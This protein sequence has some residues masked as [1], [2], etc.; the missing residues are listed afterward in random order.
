[1]AIFYEDFGHKLWKIS[2]NLA[3]ACASYC[4][5]ESLCR[6][7]LCKQGYP[8]VSSFLE[9]LSFSIEKVWKKVFENMWEPCNLRIVC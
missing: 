9:V 3:E 1:L 8:S 6:R 4:F 5:S 2:A 7:L